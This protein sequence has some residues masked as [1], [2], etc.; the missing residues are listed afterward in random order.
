MN[1]ET[2]LSCLKV[3]SV[4]ASMRRTSMPHIDFKIKDKK[5]YHSTDTKNWFLFL[6]CF[7]Y[8]DVMAD[9]WEIY[10]ISK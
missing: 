10:N 8:E 3:E 4:S 7:T 6:G 5:I 1:F 2:C 9:D